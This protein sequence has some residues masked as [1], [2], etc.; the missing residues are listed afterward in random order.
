MQ[1]TDSIKQ[2]L[3]HDVSAQRQGLYQAP[4][5]FYPAPTIL[6]LRKCLHLRKQSENKD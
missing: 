2:T 4:T 1:S 6:F 3:R 5:I